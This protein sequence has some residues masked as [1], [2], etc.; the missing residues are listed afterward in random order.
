[1][2]SSHDCCSKKEVHVT[3]S[4]GGKSAKKAVHVTESISGKSANCHLVS[5]SIQRFLLRNKSNDPFLKNTGTLSWEAVF[6]LQLQSAIKQESMSCCE[7][8]GQYPPTFTGLR[9]CRLRAL[10]SVCHRPQNW[11]YPKG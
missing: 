7:T 9:K 2:A 10:Y 5:G 11:H 4:I 1:M 6:A 3:E 8:L